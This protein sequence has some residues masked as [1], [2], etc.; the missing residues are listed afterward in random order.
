MK[1]K[2]QILMSTYNGEKYLNEQLE[3]ILIQKGK[4]EIKLLV[5]DD[6]SSDRTLDILKNYS[7]KIEMTII[8]GENI[9]VNSS[10]RELFLNCDISCDYFAISDQDDVWLENKLKIAVEKLEFENFNGLKMY[11]SRSIVT[12]RNLNILGQTQDSENKASY[13]N[14]MVQNICP[15]HTQVFNKEV[16]LEL[17]EN[18]SDKIFVIDWWIYL[19]VSATGKLIFDRKCTVKHRQH[20]VN[21][22]GY[23]LNFFKKTKN[24]MINLKKYKKSPVSEQLYSFFEIYKHKMKEEYKNETKEFLNS[25]VNIFE[26][27][28]YILKSKVFR[29]G[30][31]ENLM[32]KL[33]YIFGKYK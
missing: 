2:I 24:R 29:F 5:R 31:L 7:K 30:K 28:K 26:R 1:K 10:L 15:G 22:A 20:G 4:F 3:S 32:F 19:L 11:A 9:G 23:E 21:S 33:L 14:A 6:G 17:K 25:Q 13:Y 18:Y 27:V 12:D 8:K 16:V